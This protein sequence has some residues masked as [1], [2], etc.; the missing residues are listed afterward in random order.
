MKMTLPKFLAATVLFSLM[1]PAVFG[2][3]GWTTHFDDAMAKAKTDNKAVLLN[4]TGSDWCP[5]CIQMKHE[6]LDTGQFREYANENLELV[7]VDFP[8]A[9]PQS[10]Q[11]KAQNKGL[12][13]KYKVGGYPTFIVL[14]SD[15]KVLG[16]QVG[17]LEGGPSAFIAK[18]EKFYKAPA[19]T[20]LGGG[21]DFDS[22]FKKPA[23]S[24][25]Q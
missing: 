7:E 10:E 25:P 1:A 8:D 24:G 20:G 4:F 16:K 5:Y 3:T 9:K 23:G 14:N 2:Q 6:V 19:R 21:D 12:A 17:Y 18:M 11:L 22:F 15:G 13:K